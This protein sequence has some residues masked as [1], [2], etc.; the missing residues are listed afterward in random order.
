MVKLRFGRDI[1]NCLP[2]AEK[3]E[4]LVTNGIGGFAAGTVAGLLTRCYHGLL[5][6]ALA[7]P[8]QRTLLV[9]KID[10]SV[11][12]N[13]KLYHLA[14]NRW[15]GATIEPQGYINIESFHLEGTIPVWTFICGDALLEKRIWMEQGEN[16]TYTRYTYLRGNSPLTLNLTAFVNYR[17]FHGNTQGFNWQMAISPLEKGVRVI[18]Y[19]NAVPFYLL[20]SQGE[21]FPAHI[22]YYRF[23]LA[24]ERY[25]GL[26]D[27]ENHLHAASFSA[28]LK[29][30][31]SVTIAASTRPDPS[32]DGQSS[33]ESRYRYENSLINPQQPPWIQQLT[34]AADQFIVSR[35]LRDQ[36]DGKTIIAGY[37]WFGDWGRDTMISLRGLTLTTGRPAIARQ[38]LLTFSRYL[39]RGLLP[40]LL[41][42]GGEIP[43][44]NAVDAILWYFEAIRSYFNQSQD[45]E[46]L[47]TIYPALTEV[48]AWF[49]RGTRYN[50]HLDDDGLIYAG[51]TGVQL[52]WM[53][54]KVDDLVITP[55]IGKPVE[56]NALWFNAL[57]IMVQFAQYLGMDA[58]DY[59]KMREMTL[60]GFSRFWDDSLG[61]CYD[62][63]DTDK[64]NDASL[65]PNQLFAL[66][67]SVEELLNSPQKKAILDI[68]AL[69]LL[70]SRGLR[71]LDVDHPDYR[72]VYSG[73]RLKR[74]SAYHQGTVWGW[75]LGAFIEAHL[76]VYRDPILAESFLT[77]MI[78]HLRDSCIG[79]L[80]EIFD[81]NAPFTTRGAFAQAWTVAEVLRVWQGIQEFRP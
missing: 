5:I 6:A 57:K 42:D 59:E 4:W 26:I 22:W 62:V 18:A 43:E 3:R 46:F 11:Q 33:L 16:T 77:P 72:G 66:S 52:T 60:K 20:I 45:F 50:I 44:Y 47:K 79:N 35:P 55:R 40:N 80:S 34:L 17:D 41:P 56:I 76:K 2:V 61:Y 15:L 31:E 71:S 12:Y 69:K 37:P 68:C 78:D 54:A 7:P 48:I 19:D 81:G 58:T 1:C 10:E 65:R 53:D 38:I 39:D 21:V 23:D 73:D 70:T 51:E 29:V 13:Q 28:T 24:V 75:L 49:R 64:G 14:S 25:R 32:L 36:P 63:L 74:D 8:T 30:G 27:R 9:T 67:L